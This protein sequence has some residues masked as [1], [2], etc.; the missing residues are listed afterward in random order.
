VV[1]VV[2]FRQASPVRGMSSFA[3]TRLALLGRMSETPVDP[4]QTLDARWAWA[5][6]CCGLLFAVGCDGAAPDDGGQA[7]PDASHAEGDASADDDSG[8]D[9]ARDGGADG[10]GEATIDAGPPAPVCPPVDCDSLPETTSAGRLR[11]LDEC[12]FGL[13]LQR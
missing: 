8:V 3:G 2:G 11:A 10:G 4:V 7:L 9:Q 12:A 6:L 5:A 1:R 13:H